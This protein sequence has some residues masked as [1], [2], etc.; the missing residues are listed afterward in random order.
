MAGVGDERH[1]SPVENSNCSKSGGSGRATIGGVLKKKQGLGQR[2]SFF[3]LRQKI[4]A[5]GKQRR[6]PG[7]RAGKEM[8]AVEHQAS[9]CCCLGERK[10][11]WYDCFG[12]L[13]RRSACRGMFHFSLHFWAKIFVCLR[14]G[15]AEEISVKYRMRRT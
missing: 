8:T 9:C 10:G 7:G 3:E 12:M 13:A 15:G 2:L 14:L 1:K 11:R 5:E 6:E 4:A